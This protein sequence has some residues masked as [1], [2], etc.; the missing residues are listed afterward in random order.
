VL[1]VAVEVFTGTGFEIRNAGIV[2]GFDGHFVWPLVCKKEV[3][4]I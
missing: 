2:V 1:D 3:I 4:R